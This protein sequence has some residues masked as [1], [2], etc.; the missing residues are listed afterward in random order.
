MAKNSIS[1]RLGG[2][3]LHNQ[4]P[5]LKGQDLPKLVIYRVSRKTLYTFHFAISQPQREGCFK[6]E[7]NRNVMNQFNENH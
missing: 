4:I 5:T 1:G 7:L 2:N 6:G 3:P